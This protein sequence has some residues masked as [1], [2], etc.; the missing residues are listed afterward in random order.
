MKPTLETW[1]AALVDAMTLEG[2]GRKGARAAAHKHGVSEGTVWRWKK[3]MREDE[4]LRALVSVKL[5]TIANESEPPSLILQKP[6]QPSVLEVL[7]QSRQALYTTAQTLEAINAKALTALSVGDRVE[8]ELLEA[9]RSGSGD[10]GAWL[11]L[12]ERLTFILNRDISPE[13]IGA[14]ARLADSTTELYQTLAGLDMAAENSRQYLEILRKVYVKTEAVPPGGDL[15]P[16]P[17]PN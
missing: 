16:M 8:Q 10:A 9:I 13:F 2:G 1:A 5:K 4:E 15:E 6:V 11:D 7:A 17:K 14:I 12:L 3:R